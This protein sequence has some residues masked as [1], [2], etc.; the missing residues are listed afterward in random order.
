MGTWGAACEGLERGRGLKLVCECGAPDASCRRVRNVAPS[1]H[2]SR[3]RPER[4]R[5]IAMERGVPP[6]EVRA[7]VDRNVGRRGRA[8]RWGGAARNFRAAR[9]R[10]CKR[11]S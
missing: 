5:Q 7:R 6:D 1:P 4:I 8:R 9:A 3:S 10:G 11:D 2:S